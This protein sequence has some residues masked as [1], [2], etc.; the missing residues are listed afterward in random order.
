M[1]TLTW[2]TRTNLARRI[3]VVAAVLVAGVLNGY[4]LSSDA[5]DG[6]RYLWASVAA[7]VPVAL[8]FGVLAE[9]RP[10]TALLGLVG[11]LAASFALEV[12]SARSVGP[13]PLP[14][15]FACV[16]LLGLSMA[17]A[18]RGRFRD[19]LEGILLAYVGLAFIFEMSV[20]L[21]NL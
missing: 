6:S 11:L 9:V 8:L 13:D 14:V 10:R 1:S 15:A 20:P 17:L 19:V 16:L 5:V 12:A 4:S 3:A 21:H 2:E 18:G 7:A